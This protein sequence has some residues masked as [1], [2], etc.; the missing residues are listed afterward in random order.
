MKIRRMFRHTIFQDVRLSSMVDISTF[1][2]RLRALRKRQGLT[3]TEVGVE[4]GVAR[5]T[6]SSWET[7]S[8]T[9]A[10]EKLVALADLYE[11]SLDWIEG[12]L[13]K[14]HMPE[15]GQFV[16]DPDKLALLALWDGMEPTSR[17][18]L[19]EIVR[20]AARNANRRDSI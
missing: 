17:K 18:G 20:L 16:N 11:A 8:D 1:G 2:S 3:P 9:P 7:G 10:R 19:M 5:N 15:I 13:D 4:I 14:V 6:I 12:R